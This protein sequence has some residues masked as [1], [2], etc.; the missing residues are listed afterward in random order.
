MVSGTNRCPALESS[1]TR[2]APG[3]QDPV[4]SASDAGQVVATVRVGPAIGGTGRSTAGVGGDCHTCAAP[5]APYQPIRY[6]VAVKVCPSLDTCRLTGS[7][8]STLVRSAQPSR[9]CVVPGRVICQCGAGVRPAV[10]RP[11]VFTG[12]PP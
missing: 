6:A 5:T 10:A 9:A 8:G 7:P 4:G 12:D 1:R 11:H 2:Y 3:G